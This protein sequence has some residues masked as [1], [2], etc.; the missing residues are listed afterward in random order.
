VQPKKKS[1]EGLIISFISYKIKILSME[2]HEMNSAAE[3]EEIEADIVRLKHELLGV[4]VALKLNRW[5]IARKDGFDPGQARDALGMWTDGGASDAVDGGNP[6]GNEVSAV[7]ADLAS[8]PLAERLAQLLGGGSEDAELTAQAVGA[9]ITYDTTR[10]GIQSIDETTERLSATL[11][12]VMD[13]MEFIPNQA[14]NVYGIA[15]HTAFATSVKAQNLDGIGRDGVEET[16]SLTDVRHYG[17]AGSIRTDVTLRNAAEEVIAIY[18]V[19][20]GGAVLSASRADQLRAR[21]GASE[22]TPVIEL[23]FQRGSSLKHEQVTEDIRAASA[24][25]TRHS[26]VRA[27]IGHQAHELHRARLLSRYDAA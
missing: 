13:T 6:F 21:T 16:F 5:I 24:P 4:K 7:F 17:V 2:E 15:V 27:A 9:T 23:H 14:P 26:H 8:F 20:T 10:T 12:D 3:V 25:D 22:Y 19:K 1:R 18:D 11:I